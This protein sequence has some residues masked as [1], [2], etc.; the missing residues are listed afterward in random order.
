MT[1]LFNYS[2]SKS[3]KT[4]EKIL[5]L[6]HTLGFSIK[7]ATVTKY[8]QIQ[9][10]LPYEGLTM[11]AVEAVIIANTDDVLAEDAEVFKK[12]LGY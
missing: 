10:D 9:S 2:A 12:F 5:M 7:I 4:Y 3:D 6:A 8:Q 1:E 11:K